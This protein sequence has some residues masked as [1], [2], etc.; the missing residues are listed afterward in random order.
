[1]SPMILEPTVPEQYEF[2]I[3][4]DTHAPLTPSRWSPPGPERSER[5]RS[6][7]P[8]RPGVGQF[9]RAVDNDVKS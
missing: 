4:V 2:V 8:V 6:S 9:S 1:M 3:G 7:R 5:M